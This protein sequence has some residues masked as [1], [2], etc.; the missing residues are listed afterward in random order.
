MAAVVATVT[1][2]LATPTFAQ[3]PTPDESSR[4]RAGSIRKEQ[5]RKAIDQA[6]EAA[7]KR[8]SPES[9]EKADPWAGLRGDS[10]TSQKK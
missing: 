7:Q 9:K 1:I 4:Q 6:Y 10:Q 3:M 2:G 8:T 5:R